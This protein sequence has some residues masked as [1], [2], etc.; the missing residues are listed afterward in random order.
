[1][2]GEWLPKDAPSVQRTESQ[3]HNHRGDG[4]HPTICGTGTEDYFNAAWGFMARVPLIAGSMTLGVFLSRMTL[5]V[6]FR[7]AEYTRT[8]LS[9]SL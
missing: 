8:F 1:M 7:I 3:L 2:R 9:R 4:D 5:M 6:L